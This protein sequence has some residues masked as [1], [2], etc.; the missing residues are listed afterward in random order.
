LIPIWLLDGGQV[1]LV[2]NKL[3]RRALLTA[4]LAVWLLLGESVFFLVAFGTGWRLF[5]KDL[6]GQGNRAIAAYFIVLLFAPGR[7]Y[8]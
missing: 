2:M 5:T 6:P 8:A 3:E 4:C 1:A 7:F